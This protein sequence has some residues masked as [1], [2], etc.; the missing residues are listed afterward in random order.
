MYIKR[1]IYENRTRFACSGSVKSLGKNRR[2]ILRLLHTPRS[3]AHRR[4][5]FCNIDALKGVLSQ[6]GG[7]ILPGKRHKGNRIDIRGIQAGD[8]VGRARARRTD[9]GGES[10]GGAEVSVGRVDRRFF[11]AHGVVTN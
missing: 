6:Q 1:Q 10:A 2:D 9:G 4:G 5:D 11:M 7:D 8:E 3:F